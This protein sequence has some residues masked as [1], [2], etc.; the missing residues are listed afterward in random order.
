MEEVIR[1]WFELGPTDDITCMLAKRLY[2]GIGQELNKNEANVIS[3]VNRFANLL[4]F[5]LAR[6]KRL[7]E[8]EVY[9]EDL[10]DQ[11][12]QHPKL[13]RVL[14]SIATTLFETTQKVSS[15]QAQ[16]LCV[17][18]ETGYQLRDCYKLFALHL[19]NHK[20]FADAKLMRLLKEACLNQL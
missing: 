6:S 19:R 11:Y 4:N 1:R 17:I 20:T 5:I 8:L 2:Q 15:M 16:L 3:T 9:F 13:R 12:T 14:V 18:L 7:V 10:P